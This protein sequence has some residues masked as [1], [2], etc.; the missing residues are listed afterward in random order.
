MPRLA[1]YVPHAIVLVERPPVGQ[2]HVAC[3]VGTG[4]LRIK[5]TGNPHTFVRQ[6]L[7]GLR[8]VHSFWKITGVCI[9]F[10]NGF[11]I[12]YSVDGEPVETMDQAATV[13]HVYLETLH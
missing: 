6:A 7:A 3:A 11:S 10:A 13:P 2:I 8:R 5:L 9:N 12:R 1:R 4:C